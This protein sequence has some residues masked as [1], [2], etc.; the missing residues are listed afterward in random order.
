VL[1]LRDLEAY[2][3]KRE[4]RP[5]YVG[6]PDCP[7]VSP[8]TEHE[9]HVPVDS[10]AEADGVQLLCPKCVI[11]N[12]G[13]VGT[14]SVI[15]WRPR[16]P[17]DVCPKPGRWEMLGTGIDDLTLHAGSSSIALT[18]GGCAAHFFIENGGIRMA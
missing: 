11:T 15:C 13:H 2:F 1:R 8:H 18:G 4:I 16:V 3:I 9:Y 7:T 17:L 5:C 10:I 14:H 12:S 6:A